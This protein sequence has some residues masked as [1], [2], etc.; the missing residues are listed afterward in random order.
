MSTAAQLLNA[1]LSGVARKL[2]MA[3]AETGAAVAELQAITTDAIA[4]GEAAG[5]FMAGHRH[6]PALHPFDRRAADLLFSAGGD[7]EHAERK[8]RVVAQRLREPLHSNPGC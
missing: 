3:Q 5:G 2:S 4:L 8:A 7:L 1:R 6:D